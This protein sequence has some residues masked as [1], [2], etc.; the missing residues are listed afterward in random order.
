MKTIHDLSDVELLKEFHDWDN[1]IKNAT[2]WGA[3]LSVAHEFRRYSEIELCRRG[4]K[5]PGN[6]P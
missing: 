6:T 3:A 2:N 1:K 4:I 5:I